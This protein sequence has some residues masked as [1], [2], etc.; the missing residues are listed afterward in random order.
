MMVARGDL[1]T[2]SDWADEWTL[3][4]AQEWLDVAAE[5]LAE[6]GFNAADLTVLD[7]LASEVLVQELS[8]IHI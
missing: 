1:F 3:G 7:G 5:R 8:L 2:L 4:L 6:R